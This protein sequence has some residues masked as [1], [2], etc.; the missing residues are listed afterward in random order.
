MNFVLAQNIYVYPEK[1]FKRVDL[2]LPPLENDKEYK[3]EIKFGT[4]IELSECSKINNIYIDFKN[5]KLKKGF[6]YHYYVLEI[7]GAVFQKANLQPEKTKCQSEKLVKKKLLSFGE[8]FIEYK[9]NSNV[10][11]FIPE[12]LTL[13]YRLWKVDSDY[14]SLK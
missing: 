9:Y 7:Q 3:I 1:G 5:L 2:N 10:P 12:N 11:F 13:E 14:K 8:S 4:E 6:D